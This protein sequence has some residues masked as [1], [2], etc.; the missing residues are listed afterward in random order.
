L[1]IIE[2]RTTKREKKN[3]RDDLEKGEKRTKNQRIKDRR[4]E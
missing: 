3:I 4:M 1:K 2:E